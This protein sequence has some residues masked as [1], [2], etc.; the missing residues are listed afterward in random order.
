MTTYGWKL[1]AEL[2]G[3]GELVRQAVAAEAAG[4]DFVAIS[5][6]FHPWLGDHDHSP[7][8]WSVL[9]AV[10]HATERVG[11]ATGLTCPIGRVNALAEHSESFGHAVLTRPQN[12]RLEQKLG[13]HFAPRFPR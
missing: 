8:A 2:H 4:C 5:D 10:A 13:N 11:I 7:F 12:G 9:G 6:H 1:M 3:P